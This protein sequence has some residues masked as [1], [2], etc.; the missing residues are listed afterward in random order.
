MPIAFIAH[1]FYYTAVSYLMSRLA[2]YI[3]NAKAWGFTP[4]LGKG[5]INGRDTHILD[6]LPFLLLSRLEQFH[7]SP[8]L[9]GDSEG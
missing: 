9:C 3:P 5:T 8:H 4:P 1:V 7:G 6:I 2:A